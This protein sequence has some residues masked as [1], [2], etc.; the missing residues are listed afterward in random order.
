[1]RAELM[2]MDQKITK[3]KQ[4][5]GVDLYDT[6]ALHARQDPDFIIESPSLEQIRGHFVT[7]FKDHK[8]LRQ[9]LALQQQGL[10]ELGERREIAFPAVP[11]EGET[12]LGGKAKNAGKAANF[13]REETMYKSKIAAVEADMKHNKKKFGVEVYLLLVH[14][15]DSQKWL[16]P[17]RDVRFLYDAARRDV[18]RLL[19]EKQQ[20]ETDLRALSGKSVI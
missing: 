15:E 19:M 3:R 16:S 10:V 6:L 17:D 2:M 12:T 1:M 8:A 13:L 20:K 5:F 18:T 14:L 4:R 7:A 11:G 9:K